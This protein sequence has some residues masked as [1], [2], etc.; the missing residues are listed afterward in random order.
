MKFHLQPIKN[1]K[2][3]VAEQSGSSL[4]PVE[5]SNETKEILTYEQLE[6]HAPTIVKIMARIQNA[7]KDQYSCSLDKFIFSQLLEHEGCIHS[8]LV[9]IGHAKSKASFEAKEERKGSGN[10]ID[11]YR[12]MILAKDKMRIEELKLLLISTIPKCIES[13]EGVKI[14][15]READPKLVGD[16]YS[17]L[18][19]TYEIRINSDLVSFEIRF[20]TEACEKVGKAEHKV[21]K[22][23][24]NRANEIN[25]IF[26]ITETQEQGEQSKKGEFYDFFARQALDSNLTVE[27]VVASCWEYL[28]VE[29][30]NITQVDS[31]KIQDFLNYSRDNAKLFVEQFRD[32]KPL[33]NL[34]SL[35]KIRQML[36]ING[37]VVDGEVLKRPNASYV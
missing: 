32:S 37:Y 24:Q 7:L 13:V 4:E 36:Y 27:E 3:K 19:A 18:N 29:P 28:Q 17:L 16:F 33:V 22:N 10:V 2:Y 1:Y 12:M 8:Q 5:A 20:N 15:S 6:K 11:P 34:N 35:E 31:I 25:A 30:R 9:T 14:E 23:K 21:Y 26:G